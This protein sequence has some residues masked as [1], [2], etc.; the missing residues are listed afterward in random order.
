MKLGQVL[1]QNGLS[2]NSLIFFFILLKEHVKN[3]L[4]KNIRDYEFSGIKPICCLVTE[5]NIFKWWR[6]SKFNWDAL[7]KVCKFDVL[8]FFFWKMKS[9]ISL[10]S[11]LLSY[12]VMS[13]YRVWPSK[14]RWLLLDLD[15][16]GCSRSVFNPKW[17]ETF[18]N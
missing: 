15:E 9:I 17:A 16:N 4:A 13:Q 2:L 18:I 1:L 8:H 12:T 14:S 5:K 7:Q 10:Y 3:E 6:G 11:Y